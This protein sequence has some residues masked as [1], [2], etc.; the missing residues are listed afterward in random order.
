[1]NKVALA[2]IRVGDVVYTGRTHFEALKKLLSNESLTAEDR[3]R[4]AL[5]GEDG[6]LDTEGNFLTREEAFELASRQHQ[7]SH[8][9]LADPEANKEFYGGDKPRLDSGILE[10]APLRVW[11]ECF[12]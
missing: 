5:D 4:M 1:M 10:S 11:R 6:F 3:S 9:T 12:R 8:P 2:A 7:I